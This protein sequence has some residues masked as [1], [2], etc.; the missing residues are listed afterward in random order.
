[1]D[2]P[3]SY[4]ILKPESGRDKRFVHAFGKAYVTGNII[5]GNDRVT[6]NNWDGGVQPEIKGDLNKLLDSIRVDKPLPM[7]KVSVMETKKAY[8]YVLA[9]AGAILPKRDAVD[10]RVIEEVKTGKIKYVENAK[11]GVG[12]EFIKRRLPEDSYKK[13]IIS[14]IS[15]VGGYPVYSGKPYI[16]TDNDG[17]PDTYEK[18]VGL[19]PKNAKD[20]SVISKTGYSNIEDYLNSLVDIKTVV[21]STK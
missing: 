21:P 15:Q 19:N 9:N 14:D 3:I 16:D 13:G 11:T 10:N 4:R 1:L 12:K 2:K 17:M 5:E 6:K 18:E 7:A 8:D 20:A